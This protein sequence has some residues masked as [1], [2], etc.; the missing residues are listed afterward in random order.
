MTTQ[1]RDIN[2]GRK[3]PSC[4]SI[5]NMSTDFGLWLRVQE[6]I[7]SKYGFVVTDVD[8]IWRNYKTSEWMTI[9]EKTY[10]KELT[11]SQMELLG[12]YDLYL[13]KSSHYRGSF[14]V[15]FEKTTPDNGKVW[16]TKIE[17]DSK[18]KWKELTKEQFLMFM[19]FEGY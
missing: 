13:R 11:R 9:E 14:A 3:C 10:G 19:Q 1:R 8:Y 2:N 7:D 6:C 17:F 16:I 4:G 15:K 5:V 18:L 12:C